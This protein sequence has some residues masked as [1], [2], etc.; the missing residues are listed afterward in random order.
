[1]NQFKGSNNSQ[2]ENDGSKIDW[3]K[4]T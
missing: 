4:M 2:S 1:M 3:N